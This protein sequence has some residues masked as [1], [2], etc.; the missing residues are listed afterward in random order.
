MI[1]RAEGSAAAPAAQ[2]GLM[3]VAAALDALL[4]GRSPI[5]PRRVSIHEATGRVLAEP[6]AAPAALPPAAVARR[7]GW[8][9]RSE[10]T[11]GAS[12]YDP[13]WLSEL[14]RRV[15]AGDALPPGADAVLP[16]DA[17][18][19][20]A[21]L[22]QALLA[23]APG[24][25]VRR[26]GEDAAAGTVLFPSG[27]RMS[28]FD[29]A[30]AQAAGVEA[31]AVREPRVGLVAQHGNPAGG[32]L[33]AAVEEAGAAVTWA[34]SLADAA[35]PGPDLLLLVGG[36]PDGAAFT[37]LA[38]GLAILPGE[39]AVP[40]RAGD[41]P[42]LLVPPLLDAA[43]GV[44]LLVLG[45]YLRRL[46]GGEPDAAQPALLTRKVT[47]TIGFTE[48]ALLRRAAPGWHPIAGG[49]LTLAALAAAEAWI[50]LP[51]ECEGLAAGTP[52]EATPFSR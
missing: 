33:A 18:L 13:A 31:C 52:V 46:G 14:P 7:D 4:A 39:G 24:E 44:A 11:I 43:V 51:P 6:I 16:E 32:V 30:L 38:A 2:P 8:A 29:A 49:D 22:A 45:P 28:A 37:S 50:A 10:A 26:S 48:L 15:R 20:E 1:R 17:V 9:L 40:L 25:A 36:A 41:V 12:A 21:G 23:A 27:R 47:S 5:A 3:S 35:A 34:G 19:V 42:A